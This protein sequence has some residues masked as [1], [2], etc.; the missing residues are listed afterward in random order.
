VAAL[1]TPPVALSCVVAAPLAGASY[2]K[3]CIEAIKGGMAC[4][5]LPFFM[6]WV[7]GLLLQPQNAIEAVVKITIG[8]ILIVFLQ[9]MITGYFF[10]DLNVLERALAGSSAVLFVLYIYNGNYALL[11]IGLIGSTFLTF[12]QLRKRR[13][14]S[15]LRV[16]AE[17]SS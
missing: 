4:W 1:I 9:I 3:T 5:L 15:L 11:A 17:P 2:L 14:M 7:P 13:L 8:A 16:E 10:T 6:I 12:W